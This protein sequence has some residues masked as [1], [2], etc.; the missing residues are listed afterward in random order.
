MKNKLLLAVCLMGCLQTYGICED[1]LS[2]LG[3]VNIKK[4]EII[5]EPVETVPAPEMELIKKEIAPALADEVE[6]TDKRVT[7]MKI[8]HDLVDGKQKEID[9]IKLDLEK[10]ELLLKKKEA[11]QKISDINKSLPQEASGISETLVMHPESL[12]AEGITA[13]DIKIN[14][15][16][17][18]QGGEEAII[19]VKG[20]PQTIFEGKEVGGMFTVET[21][22]ND[23][24]MFKQ[25]DG[26][27]FKVN[28][29]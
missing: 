11:E 22:T 19:T 10:K 12:P 3:G 29:D 9:L 16:I 21:I 14:L 6:E 25:T 1:N 17:L 28:F 4:K 5:Q 20:S 23:G 2:V 27:V 7:D 24:V 13:G 15:L 8:Y 18:S 26:S